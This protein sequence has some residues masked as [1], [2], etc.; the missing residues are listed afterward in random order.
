MPGLF[1][2]PNPT[3]AHAMALHPASGT[4][5]REAVLD[6]EEASF[7][8]PVITPEDVDALNWLARVC[9]SASAGNGFHDPRKRR[10]GIIRETSDEERIGLMHSEL[11]EMLECLR[12]GQS[13][14]E[15]FLDP[16]TGKPEGTAVELADLI[17]RALDYAG[18][19]GIPIGD[20][21]QLKMKYN[22]TRPWQHGKTS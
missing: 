14:S 3:R 17:I 7:V 1:D 18:K 19:A 21:V 4:S 15:C 11:S 5:S 12:D 22:A 13:P 20:V 2:L 8:E 6:K 16:N 10:D 9:Y